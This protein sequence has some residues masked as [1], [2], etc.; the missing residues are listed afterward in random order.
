[1]SICSRVIVGKYTARKGGIVVNSQ[2][3]G[4]QS[5]GQC[6]IPGLPWLD[7]NGKAGSGANG[8]GFGCSLALTPGMTEAGCDS[9][10]GLNNLNIDSS[11]G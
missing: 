7:V 5:G 2:V 6:G 4:T 3:V 11:C 1:M 8:G 10:T 9:C